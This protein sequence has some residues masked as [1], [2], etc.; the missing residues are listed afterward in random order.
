MSFLDRLVERDRRLAETKYATQRSASE[1][2]IR[3]KPGRN[4]RDAAAKG[5]EWEDKARKRERKRGRR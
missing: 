3:M 4:V 5:E 1:L 2:P